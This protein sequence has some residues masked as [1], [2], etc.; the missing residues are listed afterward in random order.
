MK[1]IQVVITYLIVGTA[2]ATA[3]FKVRNKIRKKM[4]NNPET[5]T[6][7][8]RCPDCSAEC[9]LRDASSTFIQNNMELCKKIET[10]ASD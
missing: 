4:I 5:D 8:H 3:I 6:L 7:Q 1:M 2:V 9:A 10:T